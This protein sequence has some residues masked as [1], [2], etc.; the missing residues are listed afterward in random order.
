[1]VRPLP[2]RARRLRHRTRSRKKLSPLKVAAIFRMTTRNPTSTGKTPIVKPLAPVADGL[3]VL[4]VEVVDGPTAVADAGTVGAADADAA[5]R[6][7]IAVLAAAV[8]VA[9]VI[10]AAIT[11]RGTI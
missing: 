7:A 11:K 10:A 2:L 4:A 3:I 6:A 5:A 9:V 1:M 8:V